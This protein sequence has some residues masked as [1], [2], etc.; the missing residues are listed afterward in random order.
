MK[1]KPFIVSP[2]NYAPALNVLGTKVTVLASNDA[3]QGYEITLQQGDEG[4]GPPLHSHAWDESFYVLKGQIEFSYD[5]KTVMCLPG[6]LV[7][8]PA[9]T[10]HGFRYGL[11]G[12]EMFEL[13]GQGSMA[14]RMF[15]ALSKEIPPGPP[16]IPKVLKVLKENGVTVANQVEV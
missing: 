8:V 13:T 16:D 2:D 7:H 10:V 11:G 9:G 5:N 6:T 14:T 4:M 15:T 3:T 12:G 1:P